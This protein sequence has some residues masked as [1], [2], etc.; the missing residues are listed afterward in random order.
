MDELK[1]ALEDAEYTHMLAVQDH[2][3]AEQVYYATLMRQAQSKDA[4]EAAKAALIQAVTG[5]EA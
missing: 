2:A 3:V 4:V 1:R 5:V